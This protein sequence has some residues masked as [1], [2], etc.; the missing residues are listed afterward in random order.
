MGVADYGAALRDFGSLPP[1]YKTA[2][3][4]SQPPVEIGVVL[5]K[6][7]PVTVRGIVLR[8]PWG[9]MRTVVLMVRL[10]LVMP[11]VGCTRFR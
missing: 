4:R 2:S 1:S 3:V 7:A 5:P 8:T 10:L 6:D 9:A 11:S